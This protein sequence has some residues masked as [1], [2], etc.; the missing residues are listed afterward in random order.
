M[1]KTADFGLFLSVSFLIRCS[2][3]VQDVFAH[4]S[5]L[6]NSRINNFVRARPTLMPCEVLIPV[7]EH[8]FLSYDSYVDCRDAFDFKAHEL[9]DFR[10]SLS[11]TAQQ[12]VLNAVRSCPVISRRAKNL[13]LSM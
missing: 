6:I 4:Y 7:T 11:N 1:E 12:A 8:S 13:I 5:F 10:G 2:V 3:V 9:D